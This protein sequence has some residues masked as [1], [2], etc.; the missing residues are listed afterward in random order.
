MTLAV[1]GALPAAP[2][3]LPVAAPRIPADHHATVAALRADVSRV[4]ELLPAA[5]TV[6]LLAG[7]DEPLVH[8]AKRATLASYGLPDVEMDISVDL[9]LL[10]AVAARG[11]APRVRSDRLDGD[12]AVLSL[13]VARGRPDVAVLPVHVPRRAGGTALAGTAA[14]LLGAAAAIDR[15]VAL[16]AASDLSAALTTASPGHLV[17]GAGAWDV[18]TVEAVRAVD[19][20]A[21]AAIGPG[22]AERVQAHGWAPLLVLLEAAASL[23]RRFDEVS[24]HAP[25]GVGQLVAG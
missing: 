2:L 12:L 7:G 15:P 10:A 8:D 3:L 22:E 14:G 17:E 24:Y 25:R 11:Q 9:E 4:I 5:A 20:T 21:L 16:I 1:L 13:L 6:V 18:A 19:P 23:G